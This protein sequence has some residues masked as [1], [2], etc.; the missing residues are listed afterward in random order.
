VYEKGWGEGSLSWRSRRPKS[1]VEALRRGGVPVFMRP[2]SKPRPRSDSARP[3]EAISP[4][5]P[6]GVRKV[7]MWMSPLR[8]VPVVMTTA[9]AG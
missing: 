8:N 4:A 9:R 1:I 6:A 3:T 2:I 7:P 5:R